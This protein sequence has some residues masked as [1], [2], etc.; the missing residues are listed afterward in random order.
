MKYVLLAST[1]LSLGLLGHSEPAAAGADGFRVAVSARRPT[2]GHRSPLI[3]AHA[4]CFTSYD[5]ACRRWPA[6]A[7]RVVRWSRHAW[8][9]AAQCLS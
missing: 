5:A 8:G 1:L 9:G 3:G 4:A 2:A 7:V 6:I